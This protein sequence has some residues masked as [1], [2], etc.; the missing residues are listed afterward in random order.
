MW[1]ANRNGSAANTQTATQL[2]TVSMYMSRGR[3]CTCSGRPGRTSASPA[4]KVSRLDQR[5]VLISLARW[6]T[7]RVTIGTTMLTARVIRK[8]PM[9]KP[10][11]RR[12]GRDMYEGSRRGW[13]SLVERPVANQV[14]RDARAHEGASQRFAVA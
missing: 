9:M 6:N 7:S 4:M 2:L 8:M 12:V 1:R 3:R 14:P 5:K 11:M 13:R 10:M